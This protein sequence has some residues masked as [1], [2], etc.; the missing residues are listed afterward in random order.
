VDAISTLTT[1]CYA[2]LTTTKNYGMRR[3]KSMSEKY[4]GKHYFV[5]NPEANGGET[6]SLTTDIWDNGDDENNIFVHQVLN[7][8]SYSNSVSLHLA[9]AVLTPTK[10]RMLA[11]QLDRRLAACYNGK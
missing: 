2:G 1:A 4:L 5:F 3:R 10:L 8:E 6:L 7:L 11:D 9:G